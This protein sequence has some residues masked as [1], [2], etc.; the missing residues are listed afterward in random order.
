VETGE[1]ASR[2]ERRAGRV[3]IFTEAGWKRWT[4][5]TFV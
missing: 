3:R 1:I 5:T 2:I 4:G